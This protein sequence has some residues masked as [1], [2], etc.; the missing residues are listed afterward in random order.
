MSDK[1]QTLLDPGFEHL[2]TGDRRRLVARIWKG[3]GDD[4]VFLSRETAN[5][6]C[7][8]CLEI[9]QQATDAAKEGPASVTCFAG[10]CDT[11]VLIK[12]GSKTVGFLQTGQVALKEPSETGF[13]RIR[14]NSPNGV[15]T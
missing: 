4:N 3:S 13:N 8:A 5:R 11:T 12:L 14:K 15:Y 1:P 7:A 10:L 2:P 9:Q 6:T